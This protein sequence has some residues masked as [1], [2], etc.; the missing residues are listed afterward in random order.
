MRG[1]RESEGDGAAG[2]TKDRARWR[3]ECE[4]EELCAA[5]SNQ[6][7]RFEMAVGKYEIYLHFAPNSAAARA[8]YC[9]RYISTRAAS[10]LLPTSTLCTSFNL[11]ETDLKLKSMGTLRKLAIR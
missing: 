6:E 7:R 9:T 11:P 3:E 8:T 5:R 1:G 10:I 2:R 4:R